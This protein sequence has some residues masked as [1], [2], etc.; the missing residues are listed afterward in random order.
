[1]SADRDP[2]EAAAV[3]RPSEYAAP[4]AL[5]SVQRRAL[6]VGGVAA[7]A[8]VAGAATAPGQFFQSY[9]VGLLL[10]LG[11]ALG[12][13]GLLMLHHLA[14]GN[15]GLVVRRT[16][17]AA[18]RTVPLLA[19]LFVPLLFGLGRLYV[20][21]RPEA[22]AG[23]P[24][25]Q[26]KAGYLGARS[27][28]ARAALYF[29]LWWA[30]AHLLARWSRQQDA[31]ANPFLAR[32]MRA[33]S[34][35]GF[36]LYVLSMT[37]ASIDWLMSL[38]PHWYSTIY[39]FYIVAGQGVSAFAFVIL[40]ALYLSGREPLARVLGPR[41][42]D[43]HAKLLLT[44]V[45]LWMYFSFSQFLIIWSGNLQEEIPFYLVRRNGGWRLVSLGLFLLYFALPFLLLLLRDVK[46]SARRLGAVAGLLLV[47]SGVDPYFQVAPAFHPQGVALHWLDLAA[48]VAVGGLWIASFVRELRRAPLLPI[49]AANLEAMQDA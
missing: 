40:V 46:R 19:L 47:M 28:A 25:L 38:Q 27:F 20:W 3:S 36:G 29:A 48:P 31:P 14:G 6:A 23:D 32:R 12:C 1:M 2:R 4:E 43:D 42:F 18:S 34:G 44:C 11:V 49:H 41:H 35:P 7:L 39:G 17:E 21:A 24:E 45:L 8:C 9:L 5:A 37:F 26:H 22:V 16:F 15:W 10:W 30:C 33:L 13:L